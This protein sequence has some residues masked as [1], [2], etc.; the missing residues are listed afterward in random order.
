M[1]YKYGQAIHKQRWFFFAVGCR[2]IALMM[3]VMSKKSL[4]LVRPSSRTLKSYRIWITN[5]HTWNQLKGRNWSNWF[6]NMSTYLVT[7]LPGLT[8]CIMMLKSRRRL[9]SNNI[10]TEWILW[11]NNISRK[12][13]NT[14][15]RIT[16]LNLATETGV[17]H[18]FLCQNLMVHVGCALSTEKWTVSLRLTPSPCPGLMTV[19]IKIG[20]AKYVT[21]FDLLKGRF[22]SQT[23]QKKSLPW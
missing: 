7:F 18:V 10:P 5:S 8:K 19:L 1:S 16:L 17:L 21:K 22:L 13:L 9:W 2:V 4:I 3:V 11:Y 15:W 23:E 6:M 14:S 20:Q 12:R